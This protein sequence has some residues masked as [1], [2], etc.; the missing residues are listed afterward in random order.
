MSDEETAVVKK[1]RIIEMLDVL[2]GSL[3]NY[4][5][6]LPLC[7]R[8]IHQLT[9]KSLKSKDLEGYFFVKVL[10]KI[11]LVYLGRDLVKNWFQIPKLFYLFSKTFY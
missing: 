8:V 9:T 1:I 3:A 11:K 6:I 10:R 4:L 7:N 5:I 2:P